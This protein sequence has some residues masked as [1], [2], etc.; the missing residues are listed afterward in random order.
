MS[1][2]PFPYLK[3]GLYAVNFATALEILGP[4]SI[5]KHINYFEV[6]PMNIYAGWD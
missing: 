2:I 4:H 6:K 3:L 5:V 1:E